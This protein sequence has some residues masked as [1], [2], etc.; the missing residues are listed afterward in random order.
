MTHAIDFASATHQAVMTI[1]TMCL[2]GALATLAITIA[3][4]FFGRAP[5]K[6]LVAGLIGAAMCA[7]MG[8]MTSLFAP[9]ESDQAAAT[10]PTPEVDWVRTGGTIL[11]ILLVLALSVCAVMATNAV[12][13]R[14]ARRRDALKDLARRRNPMVVAEMQAPD[15]ADDVRQALDSI[16]RLT[17]LAADPQ[18]QVDADALTLATKQPERIMEILIEAGDAAGGDEERRALARK[19]LASIIDIGRSSNEAAD[20]IARRLGDGL[21]TQA[22]YVRMRIGGA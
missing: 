21:D 20:R 3:L 12:R 17:K 11:A 14:A 22:R 5:F 4:V 7:A 6:T 2:F 13:A 10:V 19:A 8:V 16:A 18:D 1:K 15:M 9:E